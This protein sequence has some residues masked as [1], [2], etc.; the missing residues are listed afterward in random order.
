MDDYEVEEGPANGGLDALLTI[1]LGQ[2]IR[3]LRAVEVGWSGGRRGVL[4]AYGA[5][6]VV[7]PYVEMFYFPADTLKLALYGL[8][9][10]LVWRKDLGRGVIPGEHFCPVAAFDLDGDGTDEIWYVDNVDAG[11]PLSLKGRRLRRLD[12]MT[13]ESTGEWDWPWHARGIRPSHQFRHFILGGSAKG[14]PVLVTGSGTYG[15]MRLVG[16]APDMRPRWDVKIAADAPGARGSHMAPV[17]DVNN[18]GIDELLWGE[19]CVELHAGRELFCADRDSY[20]GHSDVI[21]P[22]FDRASGRWFIYTCRE[23]DGE[24]SPRVVL[25]DD[26]GARVWGDVERGHMD[27]GW[28]ARIGEG[29]RHVAMAI[30][31]GDKSAGRDGFFRTGMTQ[32][33]WDALTGEP[34]E[35]D[36][37]A[38]LSLPVDVNGDGYHEFAR[39]YEGTGPGTTEIIDRRGNVIGRIPGQVVLARKMLDLPGEQMLSYCP[40]GTVQ[41]WGDRNAADS[42]EARDRYANRFYRPAQP[43]AGV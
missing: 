33:A 43:V 16:W 26:G 19:R 22:T 13:G 39:G 17:C 37:D 36:F 23:S 31:I 3:Q 12:A 14:Q 30:R 29:M 9:G 1:S 35:L 8:D 42:P 41:I 10:N 40:D 15:D 4:L 2:P 25:F 20:R 32:F 38:Y 7:D 27:M 5:D 24:A 28:V 21:Q 34:C 18:D 6:S 11:H